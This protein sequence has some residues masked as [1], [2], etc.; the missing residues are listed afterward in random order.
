MQV[1]YN[2]YHIKTKYTIHLIFLILGERKCM[3]ILSLIAKG[4]NGSPGMW[5][6]EDCKQRDAGFICQKK[7]PSLASTDNLLD[8]SRIAAFSTGGQSNPGS[9]ANTLIAQFGEQLSAI[10]ELCEFQIKAIERL[11]TNFLHILH[12]Y[13]EKGKKEDL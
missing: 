12:T 1:I 3:K 2:K 6:P 4:E 7:L 13:E 8:R 9:R 5:S 10:K 11:S